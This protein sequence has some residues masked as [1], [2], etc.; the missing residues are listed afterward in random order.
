MPTRQTNRRGVA[1]AMCAES[2]I[3]SR[4]SSYW[5]LRSLYLFFTSGAN[6]S[7]ASIDEFDRTRDL[8][9]RRAGRVVRPC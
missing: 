9:H 6:T 4:R 8:S 3:W 7:L 1:S 5:S 2:R